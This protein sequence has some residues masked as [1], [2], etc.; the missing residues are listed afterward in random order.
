MSA[1]KPFLG[2]GS[3]VGDHVVAI[4]C[5]ST[6]ELSCKAFVD[7]FGQDIHHWPIL[8]YIVLGAVIYAAGLLTARLVF[9]TLFAPPTKPPDPLLQAAPVPAAT[10]G[11][12][13]PAAPPEKML[14]ALRLSN[15]VAHAVI[16]S[17]TLA[18][19]T[20]ITALFRLKR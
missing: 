11:L 9:R 18:A 6:V 8:A 7:K 13:P 16:A 14:A 1:R 12:T 17:T 5:V 2:T 20:V 3:H 4:T 15:K 10:P 19:G